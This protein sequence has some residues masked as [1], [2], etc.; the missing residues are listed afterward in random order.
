M[1]CPDC[2]SDCYDNRPKKE[3][4]KYKANAPDYACKDKDGCG[5][6]IW[7]EK[8]SAGG[9][10]GGSTGASR[11]PALPFPQLCNRYDKCVAHIVKLTAPALVKQGYTVTTSDVAAMAATLYIQANKGETQ[12]EKPAPP[13][14]PRREPEPEP[15]MPEDWDDSDPYGR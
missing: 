2:G 4:G 9:S 5:K 3:S 8:K 1:I 12:W 13:P 14:P 15:E 7:L 11:G 6:R 10:R